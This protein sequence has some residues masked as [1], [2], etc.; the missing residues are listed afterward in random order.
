MPHTFF[1]FAF[2]FMCGQHFPKRHEDFHSLK[3]LVNYLIVKLTNFKSFFFFYG[4]Y[5]CRIHLVFSH[6]QQ[7]LLGNN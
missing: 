3:H 7:L 6:L 2:Y 1:D 5:L 4:V